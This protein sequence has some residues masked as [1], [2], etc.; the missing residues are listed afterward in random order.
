MQL[1]ANYFS[2]KGIDYSNPPIDIISS[3]SFV[4]SRVAELFVAARIAKMVSQTIYIA[5]VKEKLRESTTL[6]SFF[7]Y[8]AF[9]V[10]TDTVCEAL[11]QTL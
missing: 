7:R 1:K 3:Y 8:P 5:K 9:F 6:L 11:P 2:N 10:R 4:K